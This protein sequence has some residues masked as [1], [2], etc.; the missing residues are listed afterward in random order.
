[1]PSGP[2]SSSQEYDRYDS[3]HTY[4]D[5]GSESS[6]PDGTTSKLER[7]QRLEAFSA[8]AKR[9]VDAVTANT[10]NRCLITDCLPEHAVD[11]AHLLPRVAKNSELTKLEFSWGMRRGT[12][13]V[14]TRLNVFRLR[15]DVHALVDKGGFILLPEGD[16]LE[17][18][19]RGGKP[20]F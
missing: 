12:L 1:M 17:K 7:Y 20:R 13:N 19:R 18:Y 9:R 15:K 4:A 10:G 6:T 2:S 8:A 14:D 3:D 5:S 16:V 11:Y